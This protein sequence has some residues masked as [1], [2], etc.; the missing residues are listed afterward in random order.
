MAESVGVARHTN[1]F[2]ERTDVWETLGSFVLEM[3]D[4]HAFERM[5]CRCCGV[6]DR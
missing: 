2:G 3:G 4:L 1:L 5:D 6:T